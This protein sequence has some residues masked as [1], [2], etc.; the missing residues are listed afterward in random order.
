MS[1]GS[2]LNV[3]RAGVVWRTVGSPSAGESLLRALSGDDEQERMLS[4]MSLVKAGDRSIDL[5]DRTY[6]AGG[7]T[8]PMIR[9]L[10]DL[11][12][13]RCRDLLTEIAGHEGPLGNEASDGLERLA[14]I[15]E[16]A[17]EDDSP[18]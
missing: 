15:D 3:M 18:G 9:L 8:P 11:D 7:A 16:I 12:S 5:I 10:P 6:R 4:G 2:S 13:P 17:E 14:R 1:L